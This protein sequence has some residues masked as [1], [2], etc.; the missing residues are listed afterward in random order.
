MTTN[1][2]TKEIPGW[3]VSDNGGI[4]LYDVSKLPSVVLQQGPAAF[5]KHNGDSYSLFYPDL[6]SED[7]F[8]ER[9]PEWQRLNREA[10]VATTTSHEEYEKSLKPLEKRESELYETFCML[11]KERDNLIAAAE[12]KVDFNA[13]DLPDQ[14]RI[15]RIFEC[16]D[17]H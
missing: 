15:T 17:H 3:L 7:K 9:D 10:E 13:G 2:A 1:S 11:S 8:Y 6:E 16:T 14:Y 5:K 4:S 12:I